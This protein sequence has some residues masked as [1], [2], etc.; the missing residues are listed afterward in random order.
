M[1]NAFALEVPLVTGICVGNNWED[2]E[3]PGS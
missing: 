1:R 3:P 2:L